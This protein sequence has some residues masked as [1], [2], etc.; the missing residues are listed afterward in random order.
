[1]DGDEDDAWGNSRVIVMNASR[2]PPSSPNR[3][4]MA[5]HSS[6]IHNGR[7]TGAAPEL[8]AGSHA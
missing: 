2:T 5:H 1:M 7:A 8:D 3:A 6:F 4:T